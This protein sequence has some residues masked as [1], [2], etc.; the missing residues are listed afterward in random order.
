MTVYRL[1][2]SKASIRL[3]KKL[4]EGGEGVV[5]RVDGNP[6]LLVKLY[7]TTLDAEQVSKLHAMINIRDERISKVAAWPHQLILNDTG[8]VCGFTMPVVEARDIHELYTPKSR[9]ATFPEADFRFIVRVALNVARS[10]GALHQRGIVVGD[11]N[12]KNLLVSSDATV[13]MIDCDSMQIRTPNGVATCDVGVPSFTPPELQNQGLRGRVRTAN[14]DNFGLAVLIFQL[15]F[16]GRHPFAGR[17]TGGGDIPLERAIQEFRYAY[18]PDHRAL[19]MESPPGA[20]PVEVM[21]SAIS[22]LFSKAFG[23]TGAAGQR[24][25]ADEWIVALTRLESSLIVCV[26]ADWHHYPRENRDCP[27]CRAEQQTGV[28]WF[29]RRNRVAQAA[30]TLSGLSGSYSLHHSNA[31]DAL[32]IPAIDIET[33]WN[34][35]IAIPDPGPEPSLPSERPLA[36]RYLVAQ[37]PEQNRR[38]SIK[39][40]VRNSLIAAGLSGIGVIYLLLWADSSNGGWGALLIAVGAVMFLGSLSGHHDRMAKYHA[41]LKR[42]KQEQLRAAQLSWNTA[43]D[44]WRREASRDHFERALS[45]AEKLHE[46]LKAFPERQRR[47]VNELEQRRYDR[48]LQ[49]Y[50][51]RFQI[52]QANISSINRNI[53]TTLRSYGI[54]T[55]ADVRKLKAMHVPGIG[56]VRGDN[57]LLWVGS[58]VPGFQ[59]DSSTA[60]DPRDVAEVRKKLIEEQQALIVRFL[61]LRETV[62]LSQQQILANRARL[63]PVLERTWDRY[64]KVESELEALNRK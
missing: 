16:A 32:Q 9:R 58:L 37:I 64:K 20:V 2:D 5:H 6:N 46:M 24:P 48:Q 39:R 8:V 50:L 1:A 61:A 44:E 21:G 3:A 40:T 47:L 38:S 19:R 30:N 35:V 4:A 52:N 28:Q 42:E 31:L 62:R 29:G 14:H 56:P 23:Q 10:F 43:L 60:Y 25:S 59:V 18:G 55:A 57:L 22:V 49:D 51:D 54:E 27:W 41:S 36:K 7:R 34:S 17:Y 13:M 33:L 45:E 15:L 11:V 63:M 53:A 26:K 12:E